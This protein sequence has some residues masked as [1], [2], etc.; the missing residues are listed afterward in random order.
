MLL[1]DQKGE[2]LSVG[3]EVSTLLNLSP[4]FLENNP[5]NLQLLAPAL[6]EEF[7]NGFE[8]ECP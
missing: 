8:P 3:K 1:C 2:I 7:Q 4:C 5:V 6:L